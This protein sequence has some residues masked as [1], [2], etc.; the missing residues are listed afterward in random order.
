MDRLPPHLCAYCGERG[1][2]GLRG[3]ETN[4]RAVTFYV[5]CKSCGKEDHPSLLPSDLL[6]ILRAVG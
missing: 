6:K 2:A 1:T 5:L 4:R 3:I